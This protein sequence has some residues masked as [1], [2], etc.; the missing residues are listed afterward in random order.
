MIG[1]MVFCPAFS[2]I[3]SGS[4]SAVTS[5]TSKII[6][7]PA[8]VPHIEHQSTW[9]GFYNLALSSIGFRAY[10]AFPTFA[11]VFTINN[12]RMGHG[13]FIPILGRKYQ[14]PILHDDAVSRPVKEK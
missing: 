9:S 10:A 5:K 13:I 1:A 8:V 14:L 2:K 11:V 6:P 4:N 12:G 3:R 7:T